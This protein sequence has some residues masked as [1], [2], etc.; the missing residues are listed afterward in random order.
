MATFAV[1]ETITV[2]HYV[3]AD[4]EAAAIAAAKELSPLQAD[5]IDCSPRGARSELTAEKVDD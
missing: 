4:D 3:E 5:E 1:R 2:I